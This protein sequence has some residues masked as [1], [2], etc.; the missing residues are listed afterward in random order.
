MKK[1]LLV[2]PAYNEQKNII[3]VL[4]GIK[5]CDA[6]VDILVINDCSK[7]A[8][9]EVV[10]QKGYNIISLCAN[11]GYSG[12]IQTGLK[13]ALL[14]NYQY[15]VQFDGDGQHDPR[16]INRLIEAIENEK[17][18]IVIGSRFIVKN[19]YKHGLFRILGTNMFSHIIK[20]FTKKEI[21]DPTSGLQIINRDA[22]KYYVD[23]GNYPEYPDANILILMI[24]A[25]FN[26]KEIPV[27]M[28]DRLS[29]VGMHDS[30]IKNIKYVIAM[31]YSIFL[32]VLKGKRNLK[33][34]KGIGI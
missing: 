13:Y 24:R 5:R 19:Q 16:E 20:V 27:I 31:L 12:A 14:R 4:E 7:D 10:E 2:I 25:G 22:F 34:V 6:E 21:T 30:P 17:C 18:D 8:T 15:V 29:G 28:H 33:E 1:V 3:H 32:C 23:S 9:K 11:L 26:I